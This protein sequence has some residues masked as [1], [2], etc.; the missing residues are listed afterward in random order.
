MNFTNAMG[1]T[2][3]TLLTNKD[4]TFGACR[5]I[6]PGPVF[7]SLRDN[8]MQFDRA[9]IFWQPSKGE[10]I[11]YKDLSISH[12]VNILNW[13]HKH[14][15][16]CESDSKRAHGL[17]FNTMSV[18]ETYAHLE[19]EAKY[20]TIFAFAANGAIPRKLDNGQYIVTN[21]PFFK[22]IIPMFRKWRTEYKTRNHN[23][24]PNK[25]KKINMRFQQ[26][27]DTNIVNKG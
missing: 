17:N 7:N 18:N 2:S 27:T 3:S 5:S 10:P 8:V 1:N 15:I 16:N 24:N 22:R 11:P 14:K 9:N 20:R 21:Q 26:L 19:K 6:D 4:V 12:L 25:K 23:P 13:I